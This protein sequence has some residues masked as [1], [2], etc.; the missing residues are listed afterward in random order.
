MGKIKRE[1]RRDGRCDV[2]FLQRETRAESQFVSTRKGISLDQMPP[3]ADTLNFQTA[4]VA[5]LCTTILTL[6]LGCFRWGFRQTMK[7]YPN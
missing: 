3:F 4:D 7:I 6:L 2:V 1:R 5:S